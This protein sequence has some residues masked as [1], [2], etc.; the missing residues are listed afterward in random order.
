[1]ALIDTVLQKG[2]SSNQ[3]YHLTKNGTQHKWHL[4]KMAS[5]KNDISQKWHVK[6]TLLVF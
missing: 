1:M 2:H 4:T 5:H 3:K 6:F